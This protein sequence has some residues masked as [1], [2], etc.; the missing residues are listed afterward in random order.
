[1]MSELAQTSHPLLFYHSLPIVNACV[2]DMS[3]AADAYKCSELHA[4]EDSDSEVHLTPQ[5]LQAFKASL[6]T[7]RL[8]LRFF[9]G[10]WHAFD[11]ARAGGA[12]YHL[13]L[14]AETIYHPH[15]LPSLV[16]LLQ[17]A[18]A[19]GEE[20]GVCLVAAKTVYFGVGGGIVEFVRAV[21]ACARTVRVETVWEIS[22]G[23][24][25]KVMRVRWA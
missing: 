21:E 1:M 14:T 12:P 7:Y 4:S 3:Q 9:S 17:N 18:C 11:L 10:A 20:T 25:R 8:R 22:T 23:V 19:S 16:R 5:L 2:L 6:E 13:V 15:A 24:S